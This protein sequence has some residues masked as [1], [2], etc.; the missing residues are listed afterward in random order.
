V[1][2]TIKPKSQWQTKALA[3]TFLEGIREAIPGADLQFAV[4]GKIVQLW[5][6]APTKILDLG[7]GDGVLGRFLL[8][9]FPLAH[10]VFV[11]FSDP[12]IEAAHKKLDNVAHRSIVTADF[13]T[14]QWLGAVA[15]HQPFD[16]VVSGFAIHHQPDKRKKA[17]YSEIYDLLLP[18]GLFLNLEHVAS[19]TPAGE[20]LFDEFFVDHLQHF[21]AKTNPN[22]SREAIATTYYNRPDKQENRLA[23]VEKQCHWLREIGFVDVDCFF[24]VFELA[25]FGG[26]KASNERRC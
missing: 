1:E 14:P 8:E 5:N 26:R 11:D 4:I 22:T 24:K 7:C 23:P 3:S 13:A 6:E 25:L 20:Q 10:G 17:L 2:R 21:H 19:L 9:R 12:M 16:L 18:G 15:S